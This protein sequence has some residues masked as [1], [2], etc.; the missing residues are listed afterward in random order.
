MLKMY[1]QIIYYYCRQV[2]YGELMI[3]CINILHV[4][5]CES[6]YY[7]LSIHILRCMKVDLFIRIGQS[8]V[9]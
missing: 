5:K 1:L 4:I 6:E 2:E 8:K 7:I 3:L 9:N